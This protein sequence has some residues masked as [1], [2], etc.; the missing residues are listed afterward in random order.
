M[1]RGVT[2][3]SEAARD[4]GEG[5]ARIDLASARARRLDPRDFRRRDTPRVPADTTETTPIQAPQR[6]DS[7]DALRGFAMFWIIGG[8]GL[9]LALRDMSVAKGPVISAA[10]ALVGAQFTHV[11]WEG[12]RFYDLIFPLFLFT[13]GVSIVFSLN[14]LIEREG[15][16]RAHLRVVRRAI[17]LF[18]LGIIFS[19]GVSTLWPDI[20]LLGVLQRIALCYLFASVLFMHLTARGLGA[21]LAAVLVGYWALMTFVPVPGIG[22][23]SYAIGANLAN[24]IDFHYLPGKKWAGT[25][26][27]EGLLSTL[28]AIG[29]CL[30]GVLAGM[31]LM[32]ARLAPSR[33]S[34]WLI[35][36]GA[37]MVLAGYLWALQFPIVKDIWTS[38][39]VLV[40]G[41]Y[42]L[43][44]LGALH[45]LVDVWGIR[46]WAAA[47]AWIGANAITLYFLNGLVSFE[48][49]AIR[50]VGGDVGVLLDQVVTPGTGRF[51]AHALGLAL[52]I[53][54]AGALYRR[55]IFL[56]V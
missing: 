11:E 27:S 55:K 2:A 7:V 21:A 42:S 19:G 52:A 45:H 6:I 3:M 26:D 40:S 24:W 4:T 20:R 23:G 9:A 16:L 37:A 1:L 29:T 10:G 44:L 17:I 43:M 35:G 28:P 39:F 14:P 54:L 31:L 36:G 8:D 50:L 25:W 18:A 5:G 13:I 46:A 53:A 56:R 33:K 34:M 12:F 41:G 48:R 47:F 51:V 49:F 32:S 22:A 30:I 15:H 38:S